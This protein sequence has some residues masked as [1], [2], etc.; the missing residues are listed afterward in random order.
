MSGD[1]PAQPSTVQIHVPRDRKILVPYVS[2]RGQLASSVADIYASPS[3]N[4]N[5]PGRV[6][7]LVTSF[8]RLIVLTNTDSSDRTFTLYAVESGG[9]TDA[10]RAL[11][12]AV[13]IKAG[14]TLEYKYDEHQFGLASGEKLRGLA[15]VA[16]KVTYR[17][18]VDV[19]QYAAG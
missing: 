5:L 17:V 9:T 4:A 19:L 3:I 7:D 8:V 1:I 13:T 18:N 16:S 2:A 10:T 11:F 6:T 15:S 12:S 14:Q